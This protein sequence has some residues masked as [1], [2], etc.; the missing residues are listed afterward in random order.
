MCWK[1]WKCG[2]GKCVALECAFKQLDVLDTGKKWKRDNCTRG[3]FYNEPDM[4]TL[5][6]SA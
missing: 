5:L 4:M 2:T 1:S 6:S 3:V